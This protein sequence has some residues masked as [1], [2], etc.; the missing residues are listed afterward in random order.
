[1]E[2]GILSRE[3]G[4]HFLDQGIAQ[5]FGRGVSARPEATE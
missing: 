4:I 3:Q 5:W 2:Q 1:M